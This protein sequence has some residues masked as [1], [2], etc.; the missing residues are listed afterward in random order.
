LETLLRNLKLPG[1]ADMLGERLAQAA[2]AKLGHAELLALLCGDELARRTR[3][4]WPADWPRRGSS[5]LRRSRTST[6]A[7]TPTSP[8]GSSGTWPPC[9]SSTAASRS[10]L[11]GPVGVGKTMLAQ[12]LGQLACRRGHTAAFTKTSR[13]LADLSGGHADHTWATRLRRWARPTLLIC[14]DFA[15]RELSMAQADDLYE[16]ITE[17]AGR[18]MILT[19]NRTPADW[20]PL[21]P[22]PVVAESILDRIINTAHH[23][24]MPGRS[25]RPLRR[26][27]PAPNG[28]ADTSIDS[29]ADTART[30]S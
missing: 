2:S 7:T 30:R 19:S 4:G 16:L 29:P 23:V 21:F 10:S 12:A 15:M 6:S 24:G 20:Y 13:L 22:N 18:P 5:P 25:Y 11:H 14:D 3:P 28:A 9:G 17:R 27:T 8:P 1:M 26:P